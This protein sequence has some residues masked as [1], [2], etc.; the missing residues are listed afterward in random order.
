VTYKVDVGEM[1]VL[2]HDWQPP[3]YFAVEEKVTVPVSV[4][5]YVDRKGAVRATYSVRRVAMDGEAF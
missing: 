4:N 2:L 5:G 1:T 3:G